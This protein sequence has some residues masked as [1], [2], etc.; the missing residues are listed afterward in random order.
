M[1]NRWDVAHEIVR[2]SRHNPKSR[3]AIVETVN[4]NMQ[5]KK[6]K[7]QVRI[8]PRCILSGES[9]LSDRSGDRGG[10]KD[11]WLSRLQ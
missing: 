11:L 6:S 1:S 10:V 3:I 7:C 2:V 4:T 5:I 9:N 8:L